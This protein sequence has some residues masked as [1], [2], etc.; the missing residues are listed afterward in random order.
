MH[1]VFLVKI[2]YL[3]FKVVVINILDIWHDLAQVMKEQ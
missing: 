1:P 2:I 3:F